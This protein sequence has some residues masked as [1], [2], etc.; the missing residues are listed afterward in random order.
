MRII[1][2]LLF[3]LFAYCLAGAQTPNGD[4][5]TYYTDSVLVYATR[6]VQ[7]VSTTPA[8]ITILGSADISSI[9]TTVSIEDALRKVPGLFINNRYNFAQGERISIRGLGSRSQFGVR[10]IKLLLDGLPLTFADGQSQLNTVEMGSIGMI[11][12]LRGPSAS[13]YGNAS[14]GV[15]YLH[16]QYEDSAALQI[17]PKIL[18]GS[19]GLQKR[20]LQIGGSSGGFHYIVTGSETLYEGFREFSTAHWYNLTSL[21]RYDISDSSTISLLLYLHSTPYAFNPGG[22]SKEELETDRTATRLA[23]RKSGAGKDVQQGQAGIQYSTSFGGRHHVD[24]SVFGILRTLYNPIFGRLIDLDR[25]AGGIRSIYTLEV[26]SRSSLLRLSA[27]FDAEF[28]SDTRMEYANLGISDDMASHPPDADVLTAVKKGNLLTNQ[29]ENINT[30]GLF[31]RLSLLTEKW[32]FSLGGRFDAY[33]FRVDDHLTSTQSGSVSFSRFSPSAGIVHYVSPTVHLYSN[34]STAFQTP[35]ANELGNTPSGGGFNTELRPETLLGMETGVRLFFS[36]LS[37]EATGFIFT[38]HNQIIPYQVSTNSEV[39]YYR[40]AGAT[41][42]A[43]AEL[44]LLFQPVEG[45]RVRMQYTYM[46]YVFTDYQRQDDNG[47]V[48]LQG[49]TVPGVPSHQAFAGINYDHPN[50]LSAELNA[51]WVGS[52]YA[53][54]DNGSPD[55][56]PD[57]QDLFRNPSYVVLDTR[58]GYKIAWTSWA[59]SLFGGINNLFDLTYNASII[60]NAAGNRFFEPAPGRTVYAG[61]EIPIHFGRK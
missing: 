15:I 55:G 2:L 46:H 31:S 51:Q 19:N 12:V 40:N 53:N 1:L 3:S 16:S 28:Q 8:P 27:G 30:G 56:K 49:K 42:N 48:Q 22:M 9:G 43:G 37:I 38:T 21:L 33:T 59:L 41:R 7:T 52:Y 35:S 57:V 39:T 23:V 25:R 11:E 36:R 32:L 54:D 60:P 13:L 4:T 26:P 44:S 61:I 24:I 50:G 58:V 18:A 17:T 45:L 34:I 47:T 29:R 5:T 14:G 10:N 20:Q 6:E